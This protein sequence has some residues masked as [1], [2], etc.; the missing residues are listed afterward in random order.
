MCLKKSGASH[1]IFAADVANH[2]GLNRLTKYP[3][4]P[5]PV[6]YLNFYI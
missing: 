1:I 2:Y 5:V 4:P 3:S 6:A